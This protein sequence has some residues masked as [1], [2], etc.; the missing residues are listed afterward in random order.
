MTYR[1]GHWVDLQEASAHSRFNEVTDNTVWVQAL[2]LG[3]YQ[4]PVYGEIDITPERVQ[5]F[6]EGVKS[7]VRE[8]D[9]DINYDH[10]LKTTEAA[11]WVKNADA[12]SDGLWLLVEWTKDAY[13]KIKDKAY[14]YLSAEFADEWEH[15]K[16]GQKH[17]DVIVGGGLTNRP[18]MKDVLPINLSELVTDPPK[19]DPPPPDP[20]PDPP[21]SE[22]KN[23]KDKEKEGDDS[24]DAKKLR[25]A[26]KLSETATD[27]EVLT[28]IAGL[29][30]KKDDDLPDLS[31]KSVD[32]LLKQLSEVGSNPAV[33]ALTE[34]VTVQHDQLKKFDKR[35]KEDAVDK[36]LSEL[37]HLDE[38]FKIPP[39]T[40]AQLREVMLNSPKELAEE[41]YKTYKRTLELGIVDMTERGWQP[42][43]DGSP[44]K[45]FNEAVAQLQKDGDLS[46]SDAVEQVALNDRQLYDAYREESFAGRE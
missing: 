43:G 17:K 45:R 36:R 20:P 4:H 18:F 16:T 11:G 6:A 27:E 28:A 35:T 33:K 14:R 32:E 3:K 13:K 29:S 2:P 9:P 30:E 46:Y 24:M 23:K 8:V 44:T 34:L 1:V 5:Q 7:K 21:A 41:V 12:R 15:P 38:R 42:R 37:D 26:L 25:E 40:K 10:N 39:A 31:D 19:T 22:D